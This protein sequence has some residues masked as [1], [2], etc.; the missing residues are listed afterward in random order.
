[1]THLFIF[2]NASRAANYGIGTYVRQLTEGLRQRPDWKVSFVDLNSDVKEYTLHDDEHG[3]RHYQVPTSNS[4]M[5][6]ETYCRCTFYF[7]AR[8]I[9]P[10]SDGRRV[11]LFNYYQH[12]PL[13]ALLKGQFFDARVIFVV[14]FLNWCFQLKGNKTRFRQLIASD[15]QP[16]NDDEW[17]IRS[18]MEGEKKAL[19]LAD[20]VIVLSEDTRRLLVKDYGIS[21]K[22][23]HLVYNGYGNSLCPR[24]DIQPGEP[25]IILFV[26]R[27]DEIKGLNFLIEAFRQIADKHPDTRLVVAGDGNFQLYLEQCRSLQGRVSFLGKVAGEE[28]EEVYRSAC[29]GAMPSFHEQC[30]YTAIEMMRHGIPVVG[31]DSTGLCEMLDATPELRV[32]INEEQPEEDAFTTRIAAC[33]DLLLSDK[34]VYHRASKAVAELYET[35]YKATTMIKGMEEVIDNSFRKTD[36]TLSHDYLTFIDIRMMQLINQSPDIGLDFYGMGGIGIYLWKRA[37]EMCDD[38]NK[39]YRISLLQEHLIYYIDWLQETAG[40]APLPDEILAL[41]QDMSRKGFYKTATKALLS[42]QP[43]NNTLLHL[44]SDRDI[45]QNSLKICNCKI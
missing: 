31:T 3:N 16:Q 26:G 29:I 22:K 33:M 23:L 25:R 8:H 34:V 4:K 14:H 12:F 7:L 36:Y 1:M 37:T 2:N 39:P 11:F 19:C 6:S 21:A 35:R 15:Y 27:L 41:L 17:Q 38:K 20:E 45:M 43:G 44:P 28:M 32:H 9:G 10:A 42:H 24:R 13:A 30:S 5:E 18:G 40:T